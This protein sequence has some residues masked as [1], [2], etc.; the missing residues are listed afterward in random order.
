MAFPRCWAAV[1]ARY[2]DGAAGAGTPGSDGAAPNP[3]TRGWTGV[4]YPDVGLEL[5]PPG[6]DDDEPTQPLMAVWV[7]VMETDETRRSATT[8]LP[9]DADDATMADA[10]VRCMLGAALTRSPGLLVAVRDRMR[11][12]S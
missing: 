7:M 10:M 9:P 4:M 1:R 3:G 11:R 5:E 8:Y 2:S 6:L 12:E